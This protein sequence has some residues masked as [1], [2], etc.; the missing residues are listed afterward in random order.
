MGERPESLTL[1]RVDNNGDYEPKNCKWASKI[2]QNNN[3]RDNHL[4][5]LD[6]V[7]HCMKEWSKILGINYITLSSRINIYGWKPEVALLEL[8]N[9]GMLKGPDELRVRRAAV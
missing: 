5:T 2:E 3:R 8:P 7:T 1:E 4:I 6:G 9:P